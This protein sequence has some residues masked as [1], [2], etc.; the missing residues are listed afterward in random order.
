M[1]LIAPDRPGYGESNPRPGRTVR[2]WAEDTRQL[3]D[4]LVIPAAP[5]VGWSSGVEFALACAAGSPWRVP[6]LALI[7]GSAPPDDVPGDP[8]TDVLAS[9]RADPTRSREELLARVAW[10]AERPESIMGMTGDPPP[11]DP[12]AAVRENPAA[13]AMLR[14]MFR[15]AGLR[16]AEGWVDDTIAHA[17][18]WGFRPSWVSARSTVWFGQRD[19][20]ADGADS[21]HLARVMPKATLRLEPDLGHSLPIVRWREVLEDLLG[22]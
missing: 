5:I 16:G 10:F 21:E 15:H 17:L 3:L 11:G 6:A 12:D 14:E 9:R 22:R 19:R 8:P 1:R 20:L 18:P 2:D 7:A 4:H 13:L